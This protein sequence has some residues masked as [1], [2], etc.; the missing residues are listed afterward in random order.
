MPTKDGVCAITYKEPN[1]SPLKSMKKTSLLIIVLTLF[2]KTN[3]SIIGD[4]INNL[5]IRAKF[6]VFIADTPELLILDI[7]FP[8]NIL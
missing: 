6:F 8:F 3:S 4:N 2:L 5:T 7:I 1:K